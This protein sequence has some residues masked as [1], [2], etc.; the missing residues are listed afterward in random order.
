M[1]VLTLE[2]QFWLVGNLR[3]WNYERGNTIIEEGEIGDQLFIIERGKCDIYK[4]VDDKCTKVAEMQK[5][6][7]FGE[8]GVMWDM[9]RS[10]TVVAQTSVTV[11]SLSRDDIF[12]TLTSDKIQKMRILARTQVFSSIPLFSK[13]ETQVRVLLAGSLRVDTWQPNSVVLRENRRV[14][15]ATRR[16]YIIDK[17]RCKVSQLS[18]PNE[19]EPNAVGR[20]KPIQTKR[21]V[22]VAEDRTV[23]AGSYFGMLELLYGCPHQHTLTTITEVQTLSIGFD[24]FRE[25]LNDEADELFDVMKR[26]VR[27]HLIQQVHP[28]LKLSTEEELVSVLDSAR[29]KRYAHWEVIFRKGDPMDRLLMLEEGT[30]IEYDGDADSLREHTFDSVEVEERSRPGE[31]FGTRCAIG[32]TSA[33]APFTLVAISE[34][35]ILHISKESLESLPRFKSLS[36][37]QLNRLSGTSTMLI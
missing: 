4:Y 15:P 8:L 10:A 28:L 29:T 31:T 21:S 24:E 34:C 9:P 32:K 30:C 6:D 12:R 19:Q 5:G 25:L 22:F 37:P 27:I 3:P 23:H 14:C 2:E 20:K 36:L 16:L 1:G 11:L 33:V 7:F 18:Q 17:G 35:I 26:S 13:L